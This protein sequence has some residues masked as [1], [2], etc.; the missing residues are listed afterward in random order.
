MY[1]HSISL[2]HISLKTCIYKVYI[3]IPNLANVYYNSYASF[4]DNK[5]RVH[6]PLE[7]NAKIDLFLYAIYNIYH[8]YTN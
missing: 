8:K 7:Y 2:L 3:I 1:M 5:K 6:I 4:R